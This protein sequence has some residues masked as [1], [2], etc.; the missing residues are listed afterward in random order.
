MKQD[1]RN[2]KKKSPLR[3]IAIGAAFLLCMI[4]VFCINAVTNEQ[5][6]EKQAKLSEL[7]A[8]IQVVEMANQELNEVL[9]YSDTEYLEY[10]LGV[11]HDELNLVR[12]GE[13]VFEIVS[14]D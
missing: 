5:I 11:A 9:N 1:K 10:V 2:N 7:N 14:G 12:Q 13:R 8:E 6:R 3:Y 4:F